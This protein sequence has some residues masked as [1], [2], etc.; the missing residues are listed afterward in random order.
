MKAPPMKQLFSKDEPPS[1]WGRSKGGLAGGG[2]GG[3]LNE[4]PTLKL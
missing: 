2:G 1:H 3:K 4:S